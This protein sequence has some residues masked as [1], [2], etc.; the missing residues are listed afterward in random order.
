MPLG[1]QEQLLT[2]ITRE[3]DSFARQSLEPVRF[4]PLVP[5]ASV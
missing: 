4:V 2:L 3:G 1:S 5:G